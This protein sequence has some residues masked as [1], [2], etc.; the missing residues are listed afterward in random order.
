[1]LL[2]LLVARTIC[3]FFTPALLFDTNAASVRT[4]RI[5]NA[6]ARS[7]RSRV[8]SFNMAVIH[9]ICGSVKLE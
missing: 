5:C 3:A 4:H 9:Y 2:T 7:V 8:F 6:R 1:M